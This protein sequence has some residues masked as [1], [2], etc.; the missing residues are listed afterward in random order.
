MQRID[1]S[2]STDVSYPPTNSSVHQLSF[3]T[4]YPFVLQRTYYIL[5]DQGMHIG[6]I[7][8]II[9]YCRVY[10]F[11][12]TGIAVGTDFCGLVSEELANSNFWRVQVGMQFVL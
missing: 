9:Y 7:K 12:F 11:V 10:I 8:L 6:S 1:A 3:N 5:L 4:N 2:V